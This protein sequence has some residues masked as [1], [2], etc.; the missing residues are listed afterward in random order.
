MKR[1]QGN[2]SPEGERRTNLVVDL[3]DGLPPERQD[4]LNDY[5][6]NAPQVASGITPDCAYREKDVVYPGE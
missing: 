4:A 6:M 3:I 2:E 5:L 1:V